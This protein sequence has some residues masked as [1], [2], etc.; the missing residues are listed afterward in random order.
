MAQFHWDPATYRVLMRNE[1]PA[2]DELQDA[3]A[4]A[5]RGVVTRRILDL[6][7]GTGETAA[8][9]LTLHRD[10][11][12]VG[13]DESGEMLTM[14]HQTLPASRV[15]LRVGR[16]QDPL[17]PG[18]FELVVSALAVH[19]LDGPAK[20][21]LFGRIYARLPAGGRFVLGDVVVPEKPSDAVTPV[22]GEYDLPDSIE[23]QLRWLG[24]A[25]FQA[26]VTWQ[27]GDLA[28]LVADRQYG[29]NGN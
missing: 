12:L 14:A 19:H 18:P 16:L 20:A 29:G 22:D 7:T 11:L 27:S 15:D 5:T 2:Y 1:V 8:R 25:G 9:V 13:V 4:A 21:A 3:V 26:V 24:A 6:G 23:D 10:A 17:P 28:V